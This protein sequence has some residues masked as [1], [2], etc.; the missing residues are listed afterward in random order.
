MIINIVTVIGCIGAGV[1]LGMYIASQIE[2][3][4]DNNIDDEL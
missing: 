2:K 4:I 3:S 1:A